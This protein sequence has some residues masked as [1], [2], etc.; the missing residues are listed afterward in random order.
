MNKEE[1]EELESWIHSKTLGGHKPC[2]VYEDGCDDW[3]GC[4]CVYYK[5]K[6]EG[7]NDK[8]RSNK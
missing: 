8:R 5:A 3:T 1:R 2:I 4:P 7:E 6:K